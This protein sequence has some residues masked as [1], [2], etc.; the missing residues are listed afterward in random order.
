MSINVNDSELALHPKPSQENSRKNVGGTYVD[1]ASTDE[2]NSLVNINFRKNKFFHVA[3]NYYFCE[4]DGVTYK[5][6]GGSDT[7]F[8]YTADFFVTP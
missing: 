6:I 4:Q 3:G 2:V 8:Q 5:L 7:E 1:Y